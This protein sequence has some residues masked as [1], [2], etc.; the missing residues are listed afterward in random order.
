MIMLLKRLAEEVPALRI[1]D[2]IE[3]AGRRRIEGRAK[4]GFARIGDRP[5]GQTSVSIRVVGR[6]KM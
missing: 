5:G 4:S 6:R 2:E 1:R 3:I